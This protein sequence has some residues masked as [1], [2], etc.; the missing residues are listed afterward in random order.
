MWASR[1]LSF[2]TPVPGAPL[3]NGLILAL[4]GI[5]TSLGIDQAPHTYVG[6]GGWRVLIRSGAYAGGAKLY[7]ARAV[8][9]DDTISKSVSRRIIS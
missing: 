2:W 9:N 3:L 5:L 4:I 6:L 7:R 8:S 1:L